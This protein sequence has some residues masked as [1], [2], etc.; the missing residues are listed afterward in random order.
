MDRPNRIL[1]PT[2][3]FRRDALPAGTYPPFM[4][5]THSRLVALSQDN[6][7]ASGR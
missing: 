1:V 2:D 7:P 6:A 5:I 4:G 3:H